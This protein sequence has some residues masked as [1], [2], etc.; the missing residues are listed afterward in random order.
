M[1]MAPQRSN[2]LHNF[3][4]PMSWGNITTFK[5][6]KVDSNGDLLAL[7]RRSSPETEF[8][9]GGS[10]DRRDSLKRSPSPG[11][12][13]GG[14]ARK[15]KLR[16]DGGEGIEAIRT[17]LMFDLQME[18][19]KMKGAIL[20]EGFEERP[21]PAT[22]PTEN[23]EVRPW[24]LRTRRAACK[25]P[26]GHSGG[27][28]GVGYGG[29]T[30]SSQFDFLK[31]NLTPRLRF[32]GSSSQSGEK[33]ERAKFSVLLSRQEIEQDFWMITGN[34]LPRRPKKRP[35]NIQ[36]DL[37]MVFPGLWLTEINADIYKVPDAPETAKR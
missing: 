7:D 19:D 37:D 28:S 15:S 23:D 6:L 33:K 29:G 24:N 32:V 8:L 35:K 11:F 20:R 16:S 30:K 17:K 3:D 27:G 25:A 13:A 22:S 12:F 34:K 18:A 2:P 5:C 10:S 14:S 4:M 26:K 9:K 1:A 36:K 21:P 31:P